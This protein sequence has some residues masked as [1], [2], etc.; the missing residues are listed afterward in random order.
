MRKIIEACPTCNSRGLT[1]TEV[2]CDACGAQVRSRYSLF[3]F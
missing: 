2:T 1:I 3:P